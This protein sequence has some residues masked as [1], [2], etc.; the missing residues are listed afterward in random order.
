[1]I[2]N[3]VNK[4]SRIFSPLCHFKFFL[5]NHKPKLDG[6]PVFHHS[7]CKSPKCL[8]IPLRMSKQ[9]RPSL[10]MFGWQILVINRTLGADIG[11]SSGKNNSSLNTPPSKGEPSGPVN[12]VEFQTLVLNSKLDK[13]TGDHYMKISSI[14]FIWNC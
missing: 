2:T 4:L 9:I 12:K 8:I 3:N 5:L 7:V 1:M 6:K 13:L 11:Q 10:S 14:L